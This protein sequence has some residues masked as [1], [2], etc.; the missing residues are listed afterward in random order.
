L[1]EIPISNRVKN[2]FSSGEVKA[3]KRPD[4]DRLKIEGTPFAFSISVSLPAPETSPN[5]WHDSAFLKYISIVRNAINDFKLEPNELVVVK[6]AQRRWKLSDAQI[7]A[8]HAHLTGEL[9][10]HLSTD[11]QLSAE[12]LELLASTSDCLSQLGW[13]PLHPPSN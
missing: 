9:L 1:D 5:L 6:E 10:I 13:S 4:S 12:D 3:T 11:E 2:R 8:A 7:Y